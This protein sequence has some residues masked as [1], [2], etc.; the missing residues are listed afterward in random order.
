MLP[1]WISAL[2]SILL[3]LLV[4]STMM[5]LAVVSPVAVAAE[6]AEHGAIDHWTVREILKASDSLKPK[7]NPVLER[8]KLLVILFM[9]SLIHY[10]PMITHLPPLRK[11]NRVCLVTLPIA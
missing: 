5:S 9:G 1:L 7:R 8:L 11:K 4:V 6:S 3:S 10:M 2:L